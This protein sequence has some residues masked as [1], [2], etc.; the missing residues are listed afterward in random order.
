MYVHGF[1][2][3]LPRFDP[4]EVYTVEQRAGMPAGRAAEL[5]VQVFVIGQEL[6]VLAYNLHAHTV[7]VALFQH[8]SASHFMP[9]FMQTCQI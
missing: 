2:Q 9:C 5:S 3:K 8:V 6:Q 7:F 1:T 4:G